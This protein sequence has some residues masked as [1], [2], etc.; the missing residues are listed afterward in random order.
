MAALRV[1][2]MGGRPRLQICLN[3]SARE[4]WVLAREKGVRAQKLWVCPALSSKPQTLTTLLAHLTPHLS[5]PGQPC[6]AGSRETF[7]LGTQNNRDRARE[8]VPM[9]RT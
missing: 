3:H 5:L 8:G 4:G 2:F 1:Y 9:V 6:K 7:P